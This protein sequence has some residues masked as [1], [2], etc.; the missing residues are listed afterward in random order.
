MPASRRLMRLR[1]EKRLRFLTACRLRLQREILA[2]WSQTAD[3]HARRR[4]NMSAARESQAI[5]VQADHARER[6]SGAPAMS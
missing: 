4:E 2:D 1:P 6:L 5:A 3:A